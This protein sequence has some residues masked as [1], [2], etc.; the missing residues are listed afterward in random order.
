MCVCAYVYVYT[1]THN[2]IYLN[3]GKKS[4]IQNGL[5]PPPK[6]EGGKQ[7]LWRCYHDTQNVKKE[8]VQRNPYKIWDYGV[9]VKSWNRKNVA[10]VTFADDINDGGNDKHFHRSEARIVY[11]CAKSGFMISSPGRDWTC[12]H[13][14][15]FRVLL[16]KLR[17]YHEPI[18]SLEVLANVWKGFM[19]LELT[20]EV[21]KTRERNFE[22]RRTR[23]R[24]RNVMLERGSSVRFLVQCRVY[25]LCSVAR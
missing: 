13:D 24:I 11:D 18:P 6:M 25:R 7:A 4:W 23:W 1:Y 17:P 2:Y 10:R 20:S 9:W 5:F 22:S 14:F 12:V 15:C 3:T 21:E 8:E 19:V 16:R